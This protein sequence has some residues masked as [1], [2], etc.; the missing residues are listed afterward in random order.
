MYER[1]RKVAG[2][3]K[4]RLRNGDDFLLTGKDFVGFFFKEMEKISPHFFTGVEPETK[5]SVRKAF[6]HGLSHADQT[7]CERGTI[8]TTLEVQGGKP[9]SP[10]IFLN[11]LFV[12]CYFHV[13][14]NL[15]NPYK[16]YTW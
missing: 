15:L 13:I 2:S 8:V 4:M 11:L 9:F 16:V 3:R 6:T 12:I 1:L 5:T 14:C 10:C 7:K